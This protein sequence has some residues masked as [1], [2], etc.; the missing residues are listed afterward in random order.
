MLITRF[1][2]LLHDN[3]NGEMTG[4][5]WSRAHHARIDTGG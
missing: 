3:G 4:A 5:T 1:R 2:E